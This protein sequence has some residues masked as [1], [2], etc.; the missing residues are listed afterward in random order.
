[1]SPARVPGVRR[2]RDAWEARIMIGGRSVSQSFS[3]YDEAVRWRNRTAEANARGKNVTSSLDRTSFARHWEIW[4]AGLM[5]RPNTL[6]RNDSAY[7][8]YIGPRWG[9]VQLAKISRS[10]AQAWVRELEGAGLAP[11][12]V[13]RVVQIASACIQAAVDDDI[14]ERNPFRRLHLP[15]LVHEEAR[16]VTA[17]EAHAIEMAMDEW[18]QLTVPLAFDTGLRLSELC[19]LRV[20]DVAFNR[21]GWVVHVRQIVTEP[22][23]C[24]SIGPPKTKAGIRTVPTLT[25]QVAERVAAHIASRGLGPDDQLFAGRQGGPMRPVNW[26]SRIFRPAVEAARLDDAERVTPHSLRHGAVASWIAAGVVDHYKLATWLGH[27]SPTTVTALYGHLIPEDTT[28]LTDRLT[29]AR[30]EATKSGQLLQ[31]TKVDSVRR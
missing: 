3:T 30:V 26:R 6:A 12:T 17:S 1:M 16:F 14:L 31:A 2:H 22:S 24:I 11:A 7:R 27:R 4:R 8:S 19:G 18:W 28:W 20:K 29:S 13:I 5:H 23:G 25:P 10:D 15:E 9:H 21:P